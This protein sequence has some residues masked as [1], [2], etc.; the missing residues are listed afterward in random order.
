MIKAHVK[1]VC[2]IIA[3]IALIAVMIIFPK[4]TASLYIALWFVIGLCFAA[5]IYWLIYQIFKPR[6]AEPLRDYDEFGFLTPEGKAKCMS[7]W[8][9]EE[10]Y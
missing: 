7:E 3:I 6:V 9:A 4:I 10:H 8:E 2:T 5:W 1:T